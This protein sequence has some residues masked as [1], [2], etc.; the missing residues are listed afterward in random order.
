LLLKF[1]F[2]SPPGSLANSPNVPFS[3]IS[4]DAFMKPA[5]AI[6]PSAADADAA[7]AERARIR[8]DGR[9]ADQQVHRPGCTASRRWQFFLVE[10]PG[11]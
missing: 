2:N 6:R 9:R 11:E 5:Q 4:F 10:M 8:S 7:H 1:L 3:A